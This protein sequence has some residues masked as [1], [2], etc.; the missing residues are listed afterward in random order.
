MSKRFL[1][2]PRSPRMQSVMNLKI[3]HR[4]S[5]RPLLPVN[6]ARERVSEYS[7]WNRKVP[8]CFSLP[9]YK[10]V[11][12]YPNLR[13]PRKWLAFEKLKVVRPTIPAVTT[14]TILR[15]YRRLTSETNPLYYDIIS[16][17]SDE[18]VVRC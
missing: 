14:S 2:D 11:R 13:D 5:F 15:V 9:V 1:G 16:A 12:V 10:R 17:F 6:I 4:E 3:K 8:T 18:T 7:N